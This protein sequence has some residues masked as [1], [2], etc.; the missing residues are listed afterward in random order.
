MPKSMLL[1]TTWP[2]LLLQPQRLFYVSGLRR[3]SYPLTT[4]SQQQPQRGGG[5]PSFAIPQQQGQHP[6]PPSY[7]YPPQPAV[8]QGHHPHQQQA[9]LPQGM[10][11]QQQQ[12]AT[13]PSSVPVQPVPKKKKMVATGSVDDVPLNLRTPDEETIDGRV[14]NMEAISKIR[15]AWIFKQ[16][17]NR[18]R[19]F[20]QYRG[21]SNRKLASAPRCFES[22]G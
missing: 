14:R 17:R 21:V 16:V 8:P 22:C 2:L 10:P 13:V 20:T 1:C 7:Q 4:M 18:Q 6:T 9:P 15:D 5:A 19:E 3:L 12:H 11:S